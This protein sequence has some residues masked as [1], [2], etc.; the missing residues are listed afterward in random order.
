MHF[1]DTHT[2][3]WVSC[4]GSSAEEYTALYTGSY[5]HEFGVH[6]LHHEIEEIIKRDNIS[7][8]FM[9]I[10]TYLVNPFVLEKLKKK[11]NLIIVLFQLDDEFKF[12]TLSVVY[13]TIAD[14]VLT[15]DYVSVNRYRQSGINAHFFMHPI[16]IPSP[17][18]LDK[19]KGEG[20]KVAF[21]GTVKDKPSRTKFI[22]YLI[23]RGVEVA[24]IDTSGS[25]FLERDH[26]HSVFKNTIINLSFSGITDYIKSDNPLQ[27]MKRGTKSRHLEIASSG[28]FCISEYSIA[29]SKHLEEDKEIVFFTSKEDLLNKIE[30][31][32]N[33]EE[34]RNEIAIS[35]RKAI[36][37]KFSN[38]AVSSKLSSLITSAQ[39]FK[40]KNLYG[41]S[42]DL[43][44]S[45]HFAFS[46]IGTSFPYSARLL[47]KGKF[48]TFFLDLVIII[49]FISEY[50][51]NKSLLDGFLVFI[52]SI[53]RII[54]SFL[55]ELLTPKK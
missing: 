18:D 19:F 39:E 2:E 29:A 10:S 22:E 27:K 6:F 26:M 9:E 13:A 23:E 44:C 3:S 34:K 41:E 12:E 24:V 14:L 45:R 37:E 49:K 8:I 42:L 48:R 31:Y 40:G 28:G 35:A 5:I 17:E 51:K 54:K 30:F 32:L 47:L 16:Y 33:N 38:E 52:I 50:S 36:K 55:S 20:Y 4:F 21:L 11:Y 53:Y 1:K 7:L 25:N 15:F 43:T 46:Y